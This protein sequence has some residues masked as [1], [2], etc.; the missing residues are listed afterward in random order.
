[1]YVKEDLFL[2]RPKLLLLKY[3]NIDGGV[4]LKYPAPPFYIKL[5]IMT[6][7]QISSAVYN[8]VF[9]GLRS[10]TTTKKISIEQLEDECIAERM[11]LLREYLLKG[12]LNLE[13]M[14]LSI[15]CIEVDCEYMSKCCDLQLG[16]KALHFEIPPIVYISGFNTIKFIGSIDRQVK[17]N[18]YT[19][20]SYRF[21]Q[22][23]KRGKEGPYVYIDT[24]INSNG[25]MDGYIFN[26]P[27]VKYI[28]V[29]ALFQDPRKLLEWSCCSADRESI[30]DF[31]MLSAE[32]IKRM[33]EKYLRYYRQLALQITNN[34]QSPK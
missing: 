28:S 15:N 14:F 13:E 19:D 10:T 26:L 20:E 27:Y 9:D 25:N 16:A 34:D 3:N 11:Q 30:L 1:M 8:N 17:Y 23:K 2:E 22:Y 24:S 5:N 6:L 4:G 12:F 18:V 33:T 21:H 32:V 29:V 31:G 7:E